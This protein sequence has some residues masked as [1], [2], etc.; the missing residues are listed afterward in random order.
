MA[1]QLSFPC[2]L[3]ALLF[4][5]CIAGM[6]NPTYTHRSRAMAFVEAQCRATRYPQLCVQCLSANTNSTTIQNP[7][8]LAQFALT[9]SLAKARY[10]T[11]YVTKVAAELKRKKAKEYQVVKDCLD[12]INDSVD[13]LSQ[14]VKELQLI[15][16]DGEANFYWRMSNVQT[17]VSTALTDAASCIEGFSGHAMGG[18]VKA[19]VRARV[20]N[21]AQVT[22]NALALFNRFAARHRA[23]SKP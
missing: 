23:T 20:L 15:N 5:S 1:P 16:E 19:T 9:V 17:W 21:V 12:Q 3:L 11:A 7:Q 10:T 22:S 6:A 2:L 14:S 18:K 4:A 8:Q 13:Q